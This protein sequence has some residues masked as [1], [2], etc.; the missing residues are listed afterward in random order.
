MARVGRNLA[1]R[2]LPRHMAAPNADQAARFGVGPAIAIASFDAL[3]RR[4][5]ISMQ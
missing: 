5:Q 4:K 2:L 1:P 3:S